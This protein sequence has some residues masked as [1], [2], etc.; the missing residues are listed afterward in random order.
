MFV[1]SEGGTR[2]ARAVD[3]RDQPSPSS[4][5]PIPPMEALLS[6]L[7]NPETSLRHTDYRWTRRQDRGH[8]TDQQA[9]ITAA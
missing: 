2:S 7:S 3:A 8:L 9:P 4:E 6:T 5:A 1:I